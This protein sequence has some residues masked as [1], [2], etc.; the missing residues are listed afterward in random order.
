MASET[1][2][3]R[4]NG[5]VLLLLLLLAV[6]AVVEEHV[7]GD[8]GPFSTAAVVVVNDD[9]DDD[10][11]KRNPFLICLVGF[12]L[13]RRLAFTAVS[14]LL[15][16]LLL[17]TTGSLSES[18]GAC[19]DDSR[20]SRAS[21][22]VAPRASRIISSNNVMSDLFLLFLLGMEGQQGVVVAMVMM[23]M[24]VMLESRYCRVPVSM[25]CV[26]VD[27]THGNSEFARLSGNIETVRVVS[28]RNRCHARRK[29]T[30]TPERHTVHCSPPRPQHVVLYV[31]RVPSDGFGFDRLVVMAVAR[32]RM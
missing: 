24:M 31:F 27:T 14:V 1:L 15:L 25:M 9:D 23:V 22:S 10:D 30:A 26:I 28:N 11:D 21:Y 16:L 29:P 20:R 7:V 32:I 6:M 12:P 13:P 18:F 17:S 2:G 4:S 5:S 3:N 8:D 19:F